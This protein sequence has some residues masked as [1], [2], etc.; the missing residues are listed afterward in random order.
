MKNNETTPQT[1]PSV[2]VKYFLART[3]A[4][5]LLVIPMFLLV[6]YWRVIPDWHGASHFK[7]IGASAL[8]LVVL[9]LFLALRRYKTTTYELCQ[10]CVTVTVGKI[11][12]IQ[13]VVPISSIIHC[14]KTSTPL[15][16]YFN[17][18]T[19]EFHTLQGVITISP[20]GAQEAYRIISYVARQNESTND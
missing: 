16:R 11:Y 9:D 12:E 15:K 18:E 8:V 20:V 1:L 2:A 5:Y 3:I 4:I 13:K 10:I 6:Y 7:A 17:L 19:V 14:R